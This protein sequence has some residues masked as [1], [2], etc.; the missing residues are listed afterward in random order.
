MIGISI[1]LRGQP[2][3]SVVAVQTFIGSQAIRKVAGYEAQ[4]TVR[5]HL[6]GLD[7]ARANKLGGRRTHYYSSARKSTE[8]RLEGDLI[9]INI[10]Q[11]GMPLHYYGG[12]VTAGKNSSPITGQPTKYLTIPAASEAYGRRASDF[13]DLVVVWGR[14]GKPV[15]LAMGE[16]KSAGEGAPTRGPV[17]T[18][19]TRLE[20]GRMMYWLKESV[21]LPADPTVLPTED[22]LATNIRNRL[23]NAIA[24]RFGDPAGSAEAEPQPD[25]VG[26]TD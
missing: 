18:K 16:E 8:F 10:P 12:T 7:E 21:T 4:R 6:Q 1:D 13:Q 19:K 20:P 2:L 23:S 5:E 14:G 22:K 24:R 3:Q 9:I 17:L 26:G 15:G 11:V 25:D